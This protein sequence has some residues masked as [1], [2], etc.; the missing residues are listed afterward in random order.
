M[1]KFEKGPGGLIAIIGD[2]D[3]VTGFLLA[4]IGHRDAKNHVNFLVVEPEKTR[5]EDIVEAFKSYTVRKDISII[6]INQVI[7]EEIRYVLD[8][9]DKTIPTVL[10]IPS[11]ERPYDE[12]K[13]PIMQ[14]VLKLLGV[15]D[16]D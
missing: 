14:R 7:A 1:A 16:A 11:K 12:A 2:E 8:D 3:T 9:Y 5:H 10:E 6:L 4:G 13:D 15:R